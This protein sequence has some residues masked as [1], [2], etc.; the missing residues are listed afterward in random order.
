MRG[1]QISLFPH[2][3]KSAGSS[4][5]PVGLQDSKS[6]SDSPQ[7]FFKTNVNNEDLLWNNL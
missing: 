2:L 5:A 1:W 3:Q 7:L 6:V 4:T